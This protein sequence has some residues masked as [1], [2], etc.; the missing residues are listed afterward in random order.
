LF[1]TETDEYAVVVSKKTEN[2]EDAEHLKLPITIYNY[3][4]QHELKESMLVFPVT[5]FV[6]DNAYD[7]LLV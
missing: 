7:L 2:V 5:K 3:H 6:T 4:I 1:K